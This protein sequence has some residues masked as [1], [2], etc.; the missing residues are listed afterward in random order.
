MSNFL[1]L[2][3]ILIFGVLVYYIRKFLNTTIRYKEARAAEIKRRLQVEHKNEQALKQIL[4]Q[5]L[6]DMEKLKIEVR[7]AHERHQR[8]VHYVIEDMFEKWQ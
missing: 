4:T 1:F 8:A 5:P 2:A 7:A 6:D 3:L